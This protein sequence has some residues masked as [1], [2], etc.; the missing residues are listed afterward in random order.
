MRYERELF[1]ATL[2][3]C[4]LS[5]MAYWHFYHQPL[6]REM[7]QLELNRQQAARQTIDI[8]NF[9]NE[10]GNL[11]D[12]MF[13]L[14]EQ[15]ATVDRILPTQLYQ[16]EFINYL[17]TTA[18]ANGIRLL[19]L[20]PGSIGRDE[21]LPIVRLPL[22]VR[23]ECTYFKLLDL[24]KALEDSERLIKIENFTA[25]ALGD[26]ERLD[27]ELELVLFAVAEE[28]ETDAEIFDGGGI[29]RTSTDGDR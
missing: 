10:H 18:L 28:E 15:R 8:L 26:G 29:A 16:G 27:C 19:S 23:V 25:K 12:Y 20:T 24:L 1:I 5:A 4:V 6:E 2:M 22:R 9:K 13:E 3:L 14:E 21:R 11:D 17:Q 7:L